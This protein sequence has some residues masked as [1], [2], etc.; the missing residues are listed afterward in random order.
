MV[1]SEQK[2][3]HI[4]HLDN[5]QDAMEVNEFWTSKK[6]SPWAGMCKYDNIDWW[7][8]MNQTCGIVDSKYPRGNSE[9]GPSWG[10]SESSHHICQLCKQSDWW[11]MDSPWKRK[12]LKQIL[13]KRKQVS[14]PTESSSDWYSPDVYLSF[15]WR[16]PDIHLT[17]WPSSDIPLT[18]T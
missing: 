4:G 1:N 10:E 6:C 2:K 8:W 13:Y 16:S 9:R 15:T 18:L 5:K 3:D 12:L 17:T 7:E 11:A 14:R